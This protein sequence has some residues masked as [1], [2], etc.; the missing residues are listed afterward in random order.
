[1]INLIG[2]APA[3]TFILNKG[4]VPGECEY[5]PQ[6]FGNAVLV[7]IGSQFSL[8]FVRDRGQVFIDAGDNKVGWYQL[9]YVLEFVDSMITQ[10][11]L[12]EPPEPKHLAAL[13]QEFW[14]K[15]IALFS[16]PEETS[17][18]HVFS[19]Q[20]STALLDKIFHKL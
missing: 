11:Q 8:R 5:N 14:E 17:Q 9:E 4:F 7:M 19:K 13:L 16:T 20:K 18:L 15:V 12:G 1:M 3:F 2:I 10:A 6:E